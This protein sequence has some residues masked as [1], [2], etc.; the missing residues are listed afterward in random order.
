MV[1]NERPSHDA[2]VHV[3]AIAAFE[4][5][6]LLAADQAAS[7]DD[8]LR[9]ISSVICHRLGVSRCFVYLRREDGRFQGRIGY[10][11]SGDHLDGRIRGLVTG[12]ERDAYTLEIASSLKPVVLEDASHDPRVPRRAAQRWGVCDMLGVPLVVEQQA[13]GILYIDDAGTPRTYG[14]DDVRFAQVFAA[15]SALTVRQSW[16]YHQLDER[17]RRLDRL[18]QGLAEVTRVHDTVTRAVRDGADLDAVLRVVVDL[19]GKPVVLYSPR[20]EVVSWAAPA[21]SGW[22]SAPALTTAMA[23]TRWIREEIAKLATGTSSVMLRATRESRCRRLLVRLET[24]GRCLGYLELCELG[25]PFAAIDARALEQAALAVTLKVLAVRRDAES[26]RQEREDFCTDLMYGRRDKRW[27]S[28][29]ASAFGVDVNGRHI[30][31]RAQYAR[32]GG[33]ALAHDRKRREELGGLVSRRLGPLGRTVA[34]ATVPG[35]DVLLVELAAAAGPDADNQAEER[36]CAL[37]PTLVERLAIQF[38]LVSDPVSDVTSL[39]SRMDKLK[40]VAAILVDADQQPRMVFARELDLLLLTA[41][42]HRGHGVARHARELLDPL[43]DHDAATG[44]SLVDT[45]RVFVE[46]RAQVRSTAA[47]LDIHENTVRY[48][49]NRIRELSS[50]DPERFDS[51][52]SV[53]MAF[54]AHDLTRG[55]AS[56]AARAV[57]RKVKAPPRRVL[58]P[59]G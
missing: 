55:R 40:E 22:T 17:A 34:Q 49:L 46:C 39:P 18:R 53:S 16:M 44:S 52:L 35:A 3:A 43:I 26:Q 15:L 19:L 20:M 14:D 27:L 9:L 57:R 59:A 29:H 10:R 33:I 7:F 12:D 1:V 6:A 13:I 5:V 32:D 37:L 30:L 47:A 2:D 11:A 48:R 8:V 4:K 42:A 51:L 50:V 54:Q 25:R 24:D 38:V 28:E 31:L 45:L 41:P 23:N 21:D 36:L 56:S 58:A